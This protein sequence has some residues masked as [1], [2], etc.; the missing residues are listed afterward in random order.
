MYKENYF[1]LVP[2]AGDPALSITHALV[3]LTWSSKRI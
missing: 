2:G 3:R 1:L